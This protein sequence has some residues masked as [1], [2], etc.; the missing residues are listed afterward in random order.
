MKRGTF[1]Q[2]AKY[3]KDLMKKFNMA[4]LDLVS[5]PMITTT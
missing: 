4:E 1:K 2:Q 3:M 5:T